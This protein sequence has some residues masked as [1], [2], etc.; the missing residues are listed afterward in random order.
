MLHGLYFLIHSFIHFNPSEETKAI[1]NR[2][3]FFQFFYIKNT[4]KILKV[5]QKFS[6]ISQIFFRNFFPKKNPFSQ[7]TTKFVD[8]KNTIPTPDLLGADL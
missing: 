4:Y 8:Q 7:K 1:G 6:K 2:V 5:F 3:F